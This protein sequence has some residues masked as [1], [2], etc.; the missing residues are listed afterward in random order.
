MSLTD[1]T[2]TDP[3][4][5]AVPHV[6]HFQIEEGYVTGLRFECPYDD[7]GINRPCSMVEENMEPRPEPPAGDEPEMRYWCSFHNMEPS[8]LEGHEYTANC[9]TDL[10]PDTPP[11]WAAYWQ[12]DEEYE[13]WITVDACWLRDGDHEEVDW[14]LSVTTPVA[15]ENLGQYE[16]SQLRVLDW[17]EPAP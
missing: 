2:R 11:E 14:Q 17:S 10:H 6:A 9:K 8:A 7:L 12:A 5:T 3:R 16:D 13:S 1:R 15:W 4:Y